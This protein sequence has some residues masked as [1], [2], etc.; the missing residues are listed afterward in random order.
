M[1][2]L[3]HAIKLDQ[4][5][6]H[7]K[8]QTEHHPAERA[9]RPSRSRDATLRRQWRPPTYLSL[10]SP[11]EDPRTAT[12]R[13]R[14]KRHHCVGNLRYCRLPSRPMSTSS[15]SPSL[16]PRAPVPPRAPYVTGRGFCR[17]W[18]DC[19][20]LAMRARCRPVGK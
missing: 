17:C 10:L 4:G 9:G 2:H 12:F 15:S 16:Q 5:T 11:R 13:E 19:K 6:H 20:R 14:K 7:Q 3:R 1:R 18:H 8:R